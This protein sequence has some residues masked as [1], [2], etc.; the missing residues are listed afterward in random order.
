MKTKNGFT[1]GMIAA[2]LLLIALP[3][4]AQSL[5]QQVV[6]PAGAY[7]QQ[8]PFG[9]LHWTLGEPVV[10][11]FTQSPIRLTQG[12]H[13]LYVIRTTAL[14]DDLR[15]AWN[16]RLYPNPAGEQL[17]LETS[18]NGDFTVELYNLNGQTLFTETLNGNA[19]TL[20]LTSF[21]EGIYYLRM[22]DKN[23]QRLSFKVEKIR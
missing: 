5:Q 4:R 6:A 22:T 14:D 16:V 2:A 11:I 7:Q 18:L 1:P 8:V 20:D 23:G 3:A 9:S 13:Q 21:A 17:S 15:A 12:F 19:H 10:E